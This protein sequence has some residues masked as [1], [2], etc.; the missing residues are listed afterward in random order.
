MKLVIVSRP[1]KCCALPTES[2][3]LVQEWA[4]PHSRHNF[5]V[6]S[7]KSFNLFTSMWCVGCF[8]AQWFG[9]CKKFQLCGNEHFHPSF[10]NNTW[11]Q[12]TLPMTKDSRLT[13][14]EQCLV[15]QFEYEKLISMRGFN[16]VLT[17]LNLTCG[18]SRRRLREASQAATSPS[19]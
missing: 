7:T 4:N 15:Q 1:W 16:K 13:T 12:W 3:R 5:C 10:C 14:L 2:R 6:R 9:G 19:S 18:L 17:I 8:G 11:L